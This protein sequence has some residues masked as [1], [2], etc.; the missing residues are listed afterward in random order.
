MAS[1]CRFCFLVGLHRPDHPCCSVRKAPA[2]RNPASLLYG[3]LLARR[4]RLTGAFLARNA[5]CSCLA[6]EIT[7]DP[8]PTL[9]LAIWEGKRRAHSRDPLSDVWGRFR[10]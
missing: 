6:F 5:L 10:W 2:E 3:L 9:L 8:Q 1:A 7:L 4:F